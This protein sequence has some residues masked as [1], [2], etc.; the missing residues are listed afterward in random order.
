MSVRKQ[1]ATTSKTY[2][3]DICYTKALSDAKRIHRDDEKFY[4][5]KIGDVFTSI[6]KAE[7]SRTVAYQEKDLEEWNF[8]NGR[9]RKKI[10]GANIRFNKSKIHTIR[11]IYYESVQNRNAFHRI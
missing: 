7:Y 9:W 1:R 6:S 4:M 2:A 5:D 11:R 8:I 3:M 10:D